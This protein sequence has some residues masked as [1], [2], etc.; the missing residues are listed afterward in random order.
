LER[1]RKAL[2]AV[3]EGVEKNQRC[4]KEICQ[5]VSLY[6]YQAEEANR[7]ADEER[8]QKEEANRRAEEERR[9]KEEANRRAEEERRQKEEALRKV[10]RLEALLAKK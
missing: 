3:S 1:T 9:Q 4:F 6:K 2:Q 5:M 8:R 7:R 10:E